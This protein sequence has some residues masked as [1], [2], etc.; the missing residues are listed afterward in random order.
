LS[1]FS[2]GTKNPRIP[3]P[4]FPN[5]SAFL[6]SFSRFSLSSFSFFS[7][8]FSL[9]RSFFVSPVEF[10]GCGGGGSDERE[11]ER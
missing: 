2:F 3:F 7:F 1:F 8:A 4:A 11:D 6:Q 5:S 10:V 9:S